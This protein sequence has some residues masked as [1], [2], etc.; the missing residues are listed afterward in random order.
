MPST[1][2]WELTLLE[3][4]NLQEMINIPKPKTLGLE[5][6]QS[7]SAPAAWTRMSDHTIDKKLL[8]LGP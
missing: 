7:P 1:G 3:P 8:L 4:V 6:F 2:T 5:S